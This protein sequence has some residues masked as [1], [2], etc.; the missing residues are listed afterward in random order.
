MSVRNLRLT[1]TRSGRQGQDFFIE[2]IPENIWR[3]FTAKAQTVF[4]ES[5]ETAWSNVL[6]EVIAAFCEGETQSLILTDIPGEAW[7][8]MSDA[9]KI[10]DT[11]VAQ[12][13]AILFAR[14]AEGR[15]HLLKFSHKKTD[16]SEEVPAGHTFIVYNLPDEYWTAW[17]DNASKGGWTG[18][19]MLGMIFEETAKGN[20]RVTQR[21]S[22]ATT[23]GEG[24][25]ALRPEPRT[26]A[27]A[28][29]VTRAT[30]NKRRP[31]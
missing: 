30:F 21:E 1:T 13:M 17:L 22:T 24:S 8:A 19:Q 7:K 5:G 14:A 16:G 6:T 27:D 12:T 29:N 3:E 25:G 10:I 23:I 11:S 28:G 2:D 15:L 9:V 18:E 26:T 4:P 20:L 31:D